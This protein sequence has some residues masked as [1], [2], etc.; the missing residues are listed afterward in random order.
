MSSELVKRFNQNRKT[1]RCVKISFGNMVIKAFNHERE[2]DHHQKTQAQNHNGGMFRNKGHQRPGR[3]HHDPDRNDDSNHH[4]R[5]MLH[6]PYCRNHAI[7]RKHRIQHNNLDN[8]LPEYSVHMLALFLPGM[9]FQ[10]FVQLHRSL[11]KQEYTP[12]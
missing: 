7:Q 6:H 1:D 11:K 12:K 3:S 9:P 4:D 10:P 5:K 2:T 8:D